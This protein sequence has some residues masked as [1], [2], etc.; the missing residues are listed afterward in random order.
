MSAGGAEGAAIFPVDKIEDACVAV[1]RRG[2]DGSGGA[3]YWLAEIACYYCPSGLIGGILT[4]WKQ[5]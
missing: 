3:S 2:R 5:E 1:L 4:P